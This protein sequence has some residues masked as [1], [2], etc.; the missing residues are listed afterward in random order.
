MTLARSLLLRHG[1]L[2]LELVPSLGGSI[3]AFRWRG[4]DVLRPTK[5]DAS[6]VDAVRGTA[7]YPLFPYSNR[8]AGGAF[9]FAATRHTLALN[10]GD[11]PHAIHG[12][13]WQRAWT[14]ETRTEA[15]CRMVLQHRPDDRTVREWPFAYDAAQHVVLD[16]AGLAVKLHLSNRDGRPMPA[17]M[18]LHPYFPRGPGTRLRFDAARVWLNGDDHLPARAAP[19]T[20]GWNHAAGQPVATL[21]LDNCFA[22]WNGRVE[23]EGLPGGLSATMT[24]DAPFGHLVV[25][26][27]QACGFFAVE[28][29]THMNN[30]INR[31]DVQGH[32]LRVLDPGETM[33]GTIRIAPAA[34]A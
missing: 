3:L 27:P 34:A 31:M 5:A 26:T 17:G 28:P 13:A 23:I 2:A 20:S 9:T 15:A 24:A 32:G 4:R 10:F 8:I 18:G 7:C 33:S 11:H 30:A 6:C 25:Y 14:V 1:D 22:G 12:N 29:V 19:L 16:E 21:P